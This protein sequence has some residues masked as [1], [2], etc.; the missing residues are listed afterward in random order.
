MWTAAP[1]AAAGA[2]AG[3]ATYPFLVFVQ[4]VRSADGTA[5]TPP[6]GLAVSRRLRRQS[7]PAEQPAPYQDL[8][9]AALREPALLA[10]A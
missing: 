10:G 8:S 9:T 2:G 3:V 1:P 4:R 5:V 7:T 6:N